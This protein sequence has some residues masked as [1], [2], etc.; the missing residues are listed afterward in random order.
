MVEGEQGPLLAPPPGHSAGGAAGQSAGEAGG[1]TVQAESP[2]TEN[3]KGRGG[4][5]VVALIVAVLLL[6]PAYFLSIGLALW[7]FAHDY[8]SADA[9]NTYAIPANSLVR[10][11]ARRCGMRSIGTHRNL[12]RCNR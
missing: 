4:R 2:M 1:V 5:L 8:L 6:P 9:V 11:I 12:F 3:P 10:N 7:L